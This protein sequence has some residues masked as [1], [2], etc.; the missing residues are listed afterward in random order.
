MQAHVRKHTNDIQCNYHDDYRSW[1]HM[2]WRS[3][4]HKESD[5]QGFILTT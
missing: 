2:G 1:D 5:G 4:L 3:H